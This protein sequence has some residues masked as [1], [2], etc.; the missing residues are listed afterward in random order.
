MKFVARCFAPPT[1]LLPICI[2]AGVACSPVRSALPPDAHVEILQTEKLV[3]HG[4]AAPHP[5][6]AT[7]AS[8]MAGSAPQYLQLND[9]TRASF[10]LRPVPGVAVMHVEQLATNQTWC[11]MTRGD[12]SGASLPG[13]FSDGIYA[14]TVEGSHSEAAMPYA[15]L[16]ER[17]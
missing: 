3:L 16:V 8:R 4:T 15:V 6:S 12:G 10:F 9:D 2:L 11:V 17:L 13:E 7:C 14:I 5:E 1:A